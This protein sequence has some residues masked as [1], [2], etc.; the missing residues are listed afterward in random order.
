MPPS[1]VPPA[2]F[3]GRNSSSFF[4]STIDLS[5]TSRFSAWWSC[6][7]ISASPNLSN[8]PT[9]PSSNPSSIRAAKSRVV[10]C[11]SRVAFTAPLLRDA[12]S[13]L[14]QP[15]LFRSAPAKHT[16]KCMHIRPS[17]QTKLRVLCHPI[18]ALND[19]AA[20]AVVFV[21]RWNLLTCTI[22]ACHTVENQTRL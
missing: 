20:A 12:V 2:R 10:A 18:P 8:G 21:K 6:D 22:D 4:R 16:N 5:A 14:K 3:R 19:A 17:C 11:R 15:P 9:P 13:V 1:L 7:I